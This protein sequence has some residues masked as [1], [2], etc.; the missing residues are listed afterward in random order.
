MYFIKRCPLFGA[1]FSD[2][3]NT[4]EKDTSNKG[5]L[6]IR[7]TW[8]CPVVYYTTVEHLNKGH[9]GANDFVPCRE[10]VLISEVK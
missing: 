10:G 8:F 2:I 4:L 1:S 3:S 5:H 6:S 7:D 9:Y